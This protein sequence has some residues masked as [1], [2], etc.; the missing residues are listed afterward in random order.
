M[1]V[2]TSEARVVGPM[3]ARTF[4]IRHR[5]QFGPLRPHPRAQLGHA[6]HMTLAIT[7]ADAAK[8]Q[9]FNADFYTVAAT[10][11]PVLFLALTLQGDF[12]KTLLRGM[13]DHRI[14][15]PPLRFRGVVRRPACLGAYFADNKDRIAFQVA[16]F[17][18]LALF[19]GEIL[20]L[21]SLAYGHAVWGTTW[22]VLTS[23]IFL[24]VTAG[25]A[26]VI[27]F[28]TGIRDANRRHWL[29]PP[30][31]PPAPGTAAPAAPA[32]CSPP[33]KTD[34]TGGTG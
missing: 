10:V 14:N 22:V 13:L 5:D 33:T 17:T 1:H 21:V 9:A 28:A 19:V 2:A 7:L 34:P 26:A 32:A 27:P 29:G 31:E 11:I 20:A 18:F 24:T 15:Q 4:V 25:I 3:L 6:D 12:W 30:S 23:T 16:W 8:P